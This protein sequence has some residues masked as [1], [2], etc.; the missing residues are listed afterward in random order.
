MQQSNWLR[1]P[2]ER[3]MICVSAT[4]GIVNK[5][6]FDNSSRT[7]DERE[8]IPTPS[9]SLPNMTCIEHI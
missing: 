1:A 6:F 3:D 7:N 4:K 9:D 2:D 5:M 8:K